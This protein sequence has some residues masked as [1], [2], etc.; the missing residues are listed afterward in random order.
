MFQFT[1]PTSGQIQKTVLVHSASVHIWNPILLTNY[2]DKTD[3]V[4][5]S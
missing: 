2:I 3:H 4:Q 1:E 5:I